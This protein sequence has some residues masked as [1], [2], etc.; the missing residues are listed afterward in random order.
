MLPTGLTR[1]P[2]DWDKVQILE[3]TAGSGTAPDARSMDAAGVCAADTL[4]A[5]TPPLAAQ[6]RRI[7]D[8]WELISAPLSIWTHWHTTSQLLTAILE[9]QPEQDFG[10]RMMAPDAS[11]TV[12]LTLPRDFSL[13]RKSL[14]E[15]D[16]LVIGRDALF[17]AGFLG[18]VIDVGAQSMTVRPG[19]VYRSQRRIHRRYAVHPPMVVG[20][21][22]AHGN[23]PSI[24][25]H[26]ADI[27]M[28]GAAFLADFHGAP[29]QSM[30]GIDPRSAGVLSTT[31]PAAGQLFWIALPRPEFGDSLELSAAFIRQRAIPG[32][33]RTILW[34]FAWQQITAFADLEAWIDTHASA[35]HTR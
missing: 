27:S 29:A 34:T 19:P 23:S 5:S 25:V 2:T 32:D 7:F 17:H 31:W 3:W 30:R 12:C 33:G 21:R 1:M 8:R 10:M 13:D 15:R 35:V 9:C 22:E 16:T 28:G 4:S 11:G 24:F 18:Q 6:A 26:L 20:L 14:M